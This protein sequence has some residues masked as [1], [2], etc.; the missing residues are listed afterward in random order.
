MGNDA[1]A[2]G[3]HGQLPPP[4]RAVEGFRPTR[5]KNALLFVGTLILLAATSEVVLR[6]V[7][8]PENL[9]SV[10]R[11]D[12][13]LG[14]ALKPNASV[15]SVDGET[16][17]DYRIRTNSLGLRD[18]EI[19]KEKKKGTRRVLIIGDSI[20]FGTGVDAEWRFSD[21]LSRALGP[22]V[23]V[24]NSAVCGWGTD[25][26]LLYYEKAG[27]DLA[28]DL[29]ILTFTMANDVL[30]NM[31]DH[32]FLESAPK[33]RFVAR[34]GDLSLERAKIEARD[35]RTHHRI[36]S[37]LRKSCVLL[38]AKRRIDALRYEG[39]VK[40]EGA[41]GHPGFDKE[42]FERDYSHWSVY[43]SSYGPQFEDAWAVTE[44]VLDRFSR[45]CAE[46]GAELV[47]FAFPLKLEVDDGW[48]R[49]LLHHFDIDS[50][51]LDF[52]RPYARLGEIC[53]ERGIEFVYPLESF[54]EASR[55]RRLYF[56]KDSHPDVYGH[57]A[58]ATALVGLLHDKFFMN[59]QIAERDRA[60]ITP[61]AGGPGGPLGFPGGSRGRAGQTP[62]NR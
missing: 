17:L 32:L 28:P 26:E 58:A 21:F 50:T 20:A 27:S 51:L 4:T 1:D 43:E 59:F 2:T 56:T 39:R 34:D 29:V 44:A 12:E 60:Y 11:F 14:W 45:R 3:P 46:D 55:S 9:E 53:R 15:R 62:R 25:Q 7:Y 49:E 61:D 30:N 37:T 16:G 18:R 23:E 47:V 38:F 31:L 22:D 54:R 24:V 33:P 57:A 19:S 36:K 52:D 5:L 6:A 35:P 13:T 8:H 10:V 40:R 42:G 48:R 41:K